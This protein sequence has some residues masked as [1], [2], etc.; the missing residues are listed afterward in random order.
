M[1]PTL[2]RNRWS[3]PFDVMHQDLDRM[4]QSWWGGEDPNGEGVLGAYPVDIRED[5]EHLYVEAEMPGFK[6]DEVQVTLEN[7]VLTI[8]GQ[9]KVEETQGDSHLRERRFTRVARSFTLPNTVDESKVDAKLENGVLQLTLS[10]RE[11]VKPRKI[12]VK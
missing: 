5:A 6:R 2:R 3:N 1:L 4:L 11:E 8:Q 10:K 12:E 7:G 9:R